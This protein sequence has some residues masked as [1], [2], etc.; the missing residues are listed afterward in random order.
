LD[1]SQRALETARTIT[2]V[3]PTIHD[4]AVHVR[5]LDRPEADYYLV[6]LDGALAAIDATDGKPLTWAKVANPDLPVD[7]AQARELASLP[8]DASAE[9][10]WQSST[11]SRSLLYPI[12]E[13]RLRGQTIYVDQQRR[14][15]SALGVQGR[16]G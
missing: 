12:W 8:S 10:V 1:A 15:W 5:R 4:H 11:A 6:V 9:L 14:R 13:I 16:G 7:E 2:G 3:P